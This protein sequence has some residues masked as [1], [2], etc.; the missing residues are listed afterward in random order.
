M[1]A[2]PCVKWPAGYPEVA[3]ALLCLLA[4]SGILASLFVLTAPWRPRSAFARLPRLQL[5]WMG[6]FSLF[7]SLGLLLIFLPPLLG[8]NR[9]T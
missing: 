2:I 4:A 1:L 9:C 8:F 3:P 5:A 6:A 7:A